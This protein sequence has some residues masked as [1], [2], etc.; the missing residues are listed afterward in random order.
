M[1]LEARARAR[2]GF[3]RCRRIEQRLNHV[4]GSNKL[5]TGLP[6]LNLRLVQIRFFINIM[7]PKSKYG[8]LTGRKRNYREH[9]II[10]GRG[11]PALTL[12][13][14]CETVRHARARFIIQPHSGNEESP[15]RLMSV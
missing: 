15:V 2:R 8:V 9:F 10:S 4:Y 5:P 7:V 14:G 1:K 13:Y 12:D 11:T 6:W 3:W